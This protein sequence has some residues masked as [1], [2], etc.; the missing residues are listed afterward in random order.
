MKRIIDNGKLPPTPQAALDKYNANLFVLD[1]YLFDKQLAFIRDPNP[2]KIAVC[3]RRSGKSVACAAHLVSNA[4]MIPDSNNV[5]ITMTGTSGKRIIW[6]QFKKLNRDFDLKAK[7]N[8]IES[9]LTFKNG[10]TVYIV[11]AK[12]SSEIDKLRGQAMHLVYIDECQSFREY[13]RDLIDDVIG[14]S[15]MD[16]AGSLVLIGTPGPVE[17][18][19][20][21]EVWS[22]D[23]DFSKHAWT[24]FD[25]PFIP[26]TS[27]MTHQQVFEREL[28]RR[29]MSLADINTPSV[30]REWFG[31]W[32]TDTDSLLIKYDK[33]KSNFEDLPQRPGKWNYILGIDVGF[34]DAD[35]L[36][37]LAYHDLDP[38][39]YLVEEL[40]TEKQGLTELVQQ[41]NALR[42]RWDISKMVMDMGGLGKKMGEEMIRR[43][44]LPVEAA[45]KARK[46]ENV[47][48]LNDALRTGKF[49][50]KS[51]SKFAQDSYLVEI[52]RDKSTPDRIKVSDR[53]HSDIIDAVLYAFKCSPAYSWEAPLPKGPERGTKA[54]AD[55]Q[56]QEMWEKELSGHQNALEW[57][58]LYGEE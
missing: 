31:K 19:Y 10:S 42:N 49:R 35:A 23:N 58:K 15:L 14:P 46:M 56:S 53:Y 17:T 38:T 25:N 55:L 11:G 18:G 26:I 45:D 27:K 57:K 1:N 16:Y 54:W 13:I 39:T 32:A 20:F 51:D 12:D 33:A 34:N 2:F 43:H 21:H 3:S 24:F 9:S 44:L 29:G 47:E 36:A 41:I 8:E 22:G 48:F 30:Q 6:K 37:V 50:A 52:D 7:I 5:Y 4:I 40:V 28:R